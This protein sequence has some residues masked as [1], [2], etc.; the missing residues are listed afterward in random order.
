MVGV[1]VE[2]DSRPRGPPG[3]SSQHRQRQEAAMRDP[4]STMCHQQRCEQAHTAVH[5]V[6]SLALPS[7]KLHLGS[8][9]VQLHTRLL[10]W[11]IWLVRCA[12]YGLSLKTPSLFSYLFDLNHL[13]IC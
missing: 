13:I 4:T 9:S 1:E 2:G 10:P 5:H 7:Y 11:F 3:P 8:T 6:G 12:K